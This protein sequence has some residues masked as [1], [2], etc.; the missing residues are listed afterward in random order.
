MIYKILLNSFLLV[1]LL[2]ELIL[3][4]AQLSLSILCNTF[5]FDP[6][7]H[8]FFILLS[9]VT[10]FIYNPL[11]IKHY[12]KPSQSFTPVVLPEKILHSLVLHFII[13]IFINSKFL[14]VFAKY[15]QLYI[16]V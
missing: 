1:L 12:Q 16:L 2:L 8:S 4:Q 14:D 15:H 3:N 9:F 7:L 6:F 13:L 10:P 11:L 5:F